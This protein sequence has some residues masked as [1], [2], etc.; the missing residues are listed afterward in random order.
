MGNRSKW[1]EWVN[2]ADGLCGESA[3]NLGNDCRISSD[4]VRASMGGVLTVQSDHAEDEDDGQGHD[5]YWV[6]LET[7]RLISV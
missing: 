4:I 1:E 5:H 6:D 7:G 2:R 3:H